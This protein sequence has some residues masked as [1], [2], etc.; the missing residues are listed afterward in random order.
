[1]GRRWPVVVVGVLGIAGGAWADGVDDVA[2][3]SRIDSRCCTIWV[4]PEL[5]VTSINNRISTWRVRP[6]VRRA[7]TAGTPEGQVA[8]KC[9]TLF[10]RAKEL[11]DMYPPGIHVTIKI[12]KHRR[13]IHDVHAARYGFGT[14]AIAF[15]L[16]ETNTIYATGKDLSESVLA[17]EMAHSILDHY[18]EVRP[19]RKIEELLAMHVDAHLRD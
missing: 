4:D 3:W 7:V 12:A 6:Q 5:S 2:G 1:M 16:F 18:F 19:P 15:Y 8:A 11:L 9:D 17:H 13:Q 10:Q 14:E